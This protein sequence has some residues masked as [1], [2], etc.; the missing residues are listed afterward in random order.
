MGV[1]TGY[2][3]QRARLALSE[4]LAKGIY[5]ISGYQAYLSDF[6]GGDITCQTVDINPQ[7]SGIE[8]IQSLPGK[9]GYDSGEYISGA[10]RCHPRIAGG[11]DIDSF[12]KKVYESD[13]SLRLCCIEPKIMKVFKITRL[14]KVFDIYATQE[15]AIAD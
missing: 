2:E 6:V 5:Q 15:K 11:V 14:D 13:G 8:I 4:G 9:C 1:T 3:N 7:Y 10:A 12:S